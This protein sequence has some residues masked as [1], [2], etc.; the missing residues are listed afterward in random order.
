MDVFSF[1][2]SGLQVVMIPMN[3]FYCFVG[4][5][6]GTLIGVL[7]GIGPV[8][9]MAILLPFST[10][11]PPTAAIIM[12]A[13][14]YY[15]AQYGGSTTSIL[16]NIP[17]EASGV[18]TCIDGYQMAMQG[19]A[20]PALGISAIGSFVAGT[21]G[22]F[23]L[24]F[25]A[26]PLANLGLRF[27]PPEFF[28]LMVVGMTL[29]TYLASGSMLNALV[30]ALM[31]L[32]LSMVGQDIVTGEVRFGFGSLELASGIGIVPLAMGLFGLSQ[33]FLNLEIKIKRELF[34]MKIGG[35]L[36]NREDFKR[37]IGPVF[38]GS[39]VGFFLGIIPGGGPSLGSFFSYVAEK[40]MSKHP[41]R[42]GKGAIEGVAGPESAN[43]ACAEGCFVP[44]LTLGIPS[45]GSMAMLLGALMLYGVVPGPLLIVD[46]PEVFW[47]TIASM[48]VGNVMLLVLNLPLVG[49]WVQILKIPYRI[50]SSLIVLFTIVGSYTLRKDPF[51]ILLVIIF[52]VLGYFMKKF[53]Y[54]APPMIL[55]FVLGDRMENAFRQSLIMSSGSFSIFTTRPITAICLLVALTLLVT[56]FIPGLSRR[57][58]IISEAMQDKD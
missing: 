26:V 38:R 1:L 35:L 30:S 22:V 40:R 27:G 7:P 5:F 49:L 36:P 53:D 28:G 50:L 10:G 19:R 31:G 32:I 37:S 52:G 51:D 21:L 48:Y 41:D 6:V 20:G 33:V 8:G 56:P 43:N 4:V 23:F 11:I 24:S 46:H 2:L 45:N 58:D 34:Q 44:M 25:L 14:V 57:K 17:G 39:I 16:I 54:D 47:G 18:V 42:F 15:G 55:A 13:G 12:L 9:T 3:L 29:V